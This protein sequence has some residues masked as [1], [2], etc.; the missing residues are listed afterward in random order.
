[1]KVMGTEGAVQRPDP[2]VNLFQNLDPWLERIVPA[3]I[4]VLLGG[5]GPGDA[6]GS[7]APGSGGRSGAPRSAGPNGKAANGAVAVR[8]KRLD[9]VQIPAPAREPSRPMW[10]SPSTAA[11]GR[12]PG[13]RRH[14]TGPRPQ[15]LSWS[16]CLPSW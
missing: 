2:Q 15:C 9:T 5:V 16:G 1:M 4:A 8:L 13:R 11:P 3:H 10:P 7:A 12:A 6:G 14:A